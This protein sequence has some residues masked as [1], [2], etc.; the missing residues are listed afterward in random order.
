MLKT[1]GTESNMSLC[2]HMQAFQQ[3]AGFIWLGFVSREIFVSGYQVQKTVGFRCARVQIACPAKQIGYR[4]LLHTSGSCRPKRARISHKNK[5]SKLSSAQTKWCIPTGATLQRR[6]APCEILTSGGAISTWA[7]LPIPGELRKCP[8]SAT[9]MHLCEIFVIPSF[10]PL[11]SQW[12][13][14]STRFYCALA[15]PTFSVKRRDV[16]PSR[17]WSMKGGKTS[18]TYLHQVSFLRCCRSQKFLAIASREWVRFRFWGTEPLNPDIV[19]GKIGDVK[20]LML[21][22]L[23][24]SSCIVSL[25]FQGKAQVLRHKACQRFQ[26]LGVADWNFGQDSAKLAGTLE[27]LDSDLIFLAMQFPL[28]VFLG[29][30]Q[31]SMS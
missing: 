21:M 13:F 17:S 31:S 4:V 9:K 30:S 15:L 19:S 25:S 6:E 26:W 5:A 29:H 3:L 1:I 20:R 18:E 2:H 11:I 27:S 12:L 8:S 10:D 22:A 16:L 14:Q 23:A 28:Q 24:N 7:S